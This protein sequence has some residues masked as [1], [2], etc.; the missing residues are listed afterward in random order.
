VARASL[1]FR[2]VDP[3]IYDVGAGE[4]VAVVH[5]HART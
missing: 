1:F 5:K 3:L 4:Y 2:D